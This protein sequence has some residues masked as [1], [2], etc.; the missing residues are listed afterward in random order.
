MVMKALYYNFLIPYSPLLAMAICCCITTRYI[1]MSETWSTT[2]E[3]QK[4]VKILKSL[5]SP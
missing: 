2:L 3:F 5:P 4:S 1:L